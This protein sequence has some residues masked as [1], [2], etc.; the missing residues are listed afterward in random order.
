MAFGSTVLMLAGSPQTFLGAAS[1][2]E[3]LFLVGEILA[4]Y[5]RHV[6]NEL[7][8]TVAQIWNDGQ[9]IQDWNGRAIKLRSAYLGPAASASPAPIPRPWSTHSRT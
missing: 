9:G 7:G 8:Q 4:V 1:A 5:G 3:S 6:S 2:Q